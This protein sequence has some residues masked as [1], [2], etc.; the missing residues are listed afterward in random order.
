L[1]RVL[2]RGDVRD[3]VENWDAMVSPKVRVFFHACVKARID[4][5]E[6]ALRRWAVPGG[7]L[8]TVLGAGCSDPDRCQELEK[9]FRAHLLCALEAVAP[10]FWPETGTVSEAALARIQAETRCPSLNYLR[11]LSSE[12]CGQTPSQGTEPGASIMVLLIDS[13]DEGHTATMVMEPVSP[14]EGHIYPAPAISLIYRDPLFREGQAKAQQY[15]EERLGLRDPNR[16]IRWSL[17]MRG[18]QPFPPE[19]HGPSVSAA[20]ALLLAHLRANSQVLAPSGGIGV[21]RTSHLT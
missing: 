4:R 19:I 21:G 1:R 20:Q 8:D 15:V 13:K 18:T 3:A 2:T 6:E 16:D 9:F 12:L 7:H 14:G 10:D 5:D 11:D 17:Q